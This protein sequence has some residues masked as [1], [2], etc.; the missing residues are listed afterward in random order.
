MAAL[1]C[2]L[3]ARSRG[4]CVILRL[5][6]IDPERCKPSYQQSLQEGLAWLG[7]DWDEVV[8]QATQTQHHHAALQRLQEQG[9]LY[10]CTCSRA[11]I[12]ASGK[13]APDGSF[14]YGNTCR[15]RGLPPGGFGATDA[16][17]RVRLPAHRVVVVDESGLELAQTPAL[18]MG[19]PVVRRR[20]GAVAYQ[21]AVVVDDANSGVTRVV[22]GRDIAPSTATQVLLQRLLGNDTPIYRHHFLL[23]E[24]RGNKLAKLHGSIGLPE[25][26]RSYAAPELVGFLAFV[27][28]ILDAPLPVHPRDLIATFAWDAVSPKDKVVVASGGRLSAYTT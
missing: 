24:P 3:D 16:V 10:A 1:L 2:W 20:D 13:R 27:A 7:L 28:G 25:L 15:E 23:L 5:E 22:R 19:D 26:S 4:E 9:V 18:E 8:D 21:L 14:V 6:N 12:Q 17:L 11:Q